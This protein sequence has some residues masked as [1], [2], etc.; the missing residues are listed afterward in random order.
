MDELPA[1]LR[2]AATA[3]QPSR[4]RI[5]ARVEQGMTSS[6]VPTGSTAGPARVR[7]V[8]RGKAVSSGPRIA[9]ATLV[10]AA[11][12]AVSG[13]AV[14]AVIQ[15]HERPQAAAPRPAA[16]SSPSH[17]SSP[18]PAPH[19]PQPPQPSSTPRPSE[20]VRPS[21]QSLP[22][23]T[24]APPTTAHPARTHTQDGPLW[25][26][27]SVDGHSNRF[28]AQSNVTVKTRQPL[29]A[30][31]LELRVRQTGGVRRT[32]SWQ[33]LPGDDFALAVGEYDGVL[34]YRWTL[35]PGRTVPVGQHVFAGQ[36][37]HVAGGRDAGGD[38]YRADAATAEGKPS[39]WGDFA[40]SA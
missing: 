33:T 3:H 1:Q 37:D 11:T 18:S 34:V 21:L 14:G 13:L 22:S 24:S 31:T 40:P 16:S 9:L 5:L 39:V 27:G 20:T 36:Y 12:L 8:R 19:V 23:P 17:R 2:Q 25:A 35:K 26:D 7:E 32:G 28:W 29:T 6:A 15:D 30:L 10:T 38:T 4:A